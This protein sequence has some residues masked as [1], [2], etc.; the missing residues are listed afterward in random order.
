M[1]Q[2]GYDYDRALQL[3][4][5]PT[6][7]AQPAVPCTWRQRPPMDRPVHHTRMSRQYRADRAAARRNS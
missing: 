6:C 1:D 5:C 2:F 4:A 3:F 7:K